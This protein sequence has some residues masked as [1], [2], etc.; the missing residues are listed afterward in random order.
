MKTIIATTDFTPASANAVNY[1]ADLAVSLNAKLV[2]L[3]VVEI[4]MAASE[5]TVTENFFEEMADMADQDLD[6]LGASLIERSGGKLNLSTKVV[7]GTVAAQIKEVADDCQ[8]FAI[9]MGKKTGNSLE[10]ILLGSNTLTTVKHNPY[11]V[12]IIPEQVKFKGIHKVALACDLQNVSDTIPFK[13]LSDWISVFSPTLEI[14]HLRKREQNFNSLDA[15]ESVSLENHLSKFKP[16]F[17]FLVGDRLAE[18]LNEYARE[19]QLD[20]LI[21]IPKKH[22]FLA[23]FDKKHSGDIIV[24]NNT[25]IL[26]IHAS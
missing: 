1:A 6:N 10:R 24:H 25:S 2:L 3:N 16:T 11:P 5:I 17:H 20:L 15:T 12:L 18:R 9:V 7:L 22:G 14:V 19:Q 26:A 23:L 13:L 8:P 4:P 21:I